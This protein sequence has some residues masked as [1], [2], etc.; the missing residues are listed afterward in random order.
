MKND[1]ACFGVS[2]EK[3]RACCIEEVGNTVQHLARMMQLFERDQIKPHG[4]TTSQAYVL[5]QL[6][7]TPRLTMNELS[8]KLNARTSTMTRVVGTLVRDGLIQRSRDETDRRLVVV[9]LTE[10]GMEVS[11][12]LEADIKAYYRK[13]IDHLPEGQ[14]RDVLKSAALLVEAFEKANPNCC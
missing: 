5:T 13:I 4:F 12:V 6:L 9:E 7:K 3:N 1:C 8:E 11:R 10:K 14:V 2:D